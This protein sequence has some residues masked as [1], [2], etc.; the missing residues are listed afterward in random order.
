MLVSLCPETVLSPWLNCGCFPIHPNPRVSPKV[1]PKEKQKALS[2]L[3]SQNSVYPDEL[4]AREE[5]GE[6]PNRVTKREREP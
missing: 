2:T 3:D 5:S 4:K 6:D 1:T